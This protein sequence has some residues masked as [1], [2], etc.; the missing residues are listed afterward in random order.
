[1]G[2]PETN[3]DPPF[4]L[5][6]ASHVRL[7]T[8]DLDAS[9]A[10]YEQ[11]IGLVVSDSDNDTVYM[12]GV[13]E[14][15]HHSLTLKRTTGDAVCEAAGFR[16]FRDE[17]LDR[18]KRF[19]DQAGM[20]SE[21]IER[22]FEERSLRVVDPNGIP[23]ELCARMDVRPRTNVDFQLHRGIAALRLDHFQFAVPDVVTA[24]RFYAD[25]GFRTSGYFVDARIG[26]H[27][28]G[29]FM[30]R[31]GTPL[32]AVFMTRVGPRLHHTAYIAPDASSLFK[33]CDIAS[34]IGLG[35][36]IEYGPGRHNM[37]AGLYVY[38]RDPV[39]HRIELMQ[40]PAQTIDMD[41]QPKRWE[42]KERQGWSP[43]PPRSWIE[44]AS[45]FPNVPLREPPVRQPTAT[46]E[47]VRRA[48]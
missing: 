15:C 39:G 43:P 38:M 37:R 40:I 19:F 44:E 35:R 9:R 45:S 47:D 30:H 41:Y 4:N 27:V 13:E 42:E 5:T 10:F 8:P 25:I 29:I 22:D 24:A 28:F 36:C 32:D 31:K 16:V 12:R 17:D 21:W 14:I 18:A 33:V 11:V 7:A 34:N 6:R 1:M 26:E 20:K 46:I 2:I 48:S 23:L 3:F